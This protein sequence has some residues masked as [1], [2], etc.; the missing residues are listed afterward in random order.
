M[1][2]RRLQI[3]VMLAIFAGPMVGAAIGLTARA[4][5]LRSA[6]PR[7]RAYCESRIE[8][9]T[10]FG[11]RRLVLEDALESCVRRELWWIAQFGRVPKG[12]EEGG[13]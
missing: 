4:S 12:Y 9:S 5:N 6:A 10:P 11:M 13:R 2:S 3:A 7:V 8:A 1:P